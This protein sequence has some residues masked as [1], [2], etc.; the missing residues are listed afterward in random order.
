MKG[1]AAAQKLFVVQ[2]ILK[3]DKLDGLQKQN[4]GRSIQ[5]LEKLIVTT[6]PDTKAKSS[7]RRHGKLARAMR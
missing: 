4:R 1:P 3:P 5:K 2:E 6:G 7:I